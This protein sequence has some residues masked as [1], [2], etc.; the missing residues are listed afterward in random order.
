MKPLPNIRPMQVDDMAAIL[1]IQDVC[2]TTIVPE[3]KQSLEAKLRASPT[4]CFVAIA[5]N[6]IVG[7]LVAMPWQLGTPP[8][9]DA[10]VCVLPQQPDCLYLHDLAVAPTAR[11]SGVASV[12]VTAF[13]HRLHELALDY[14]SLIAVQASQVYW[15]RHGFRIVSLDPTCHAKLSAYG[16]NIAYME[17]A[18]GTTR[19]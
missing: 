2:Y 10:P 9:L 6:E 7:Y 11:G 15:Q 16:E 17:Y 18:V 13:M 4:T 3:S 5:Q 12:L 14:A 1:R 19:Q 8:A